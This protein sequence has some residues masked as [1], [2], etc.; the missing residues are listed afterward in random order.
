MYEPEILFA[1]AH[2]AIAHIAADASH[3]HRFLFALAGER[4]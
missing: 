1:V 3:D 2:T 4:V